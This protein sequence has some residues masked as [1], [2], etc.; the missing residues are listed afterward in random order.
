MTRKHR[1]ENVDDDVM[2][3]LMGDFMATCSEWMFASAR[4]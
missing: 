2:V 3:M 1:K 4:L